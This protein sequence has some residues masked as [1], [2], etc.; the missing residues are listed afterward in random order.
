MVVQ[1]CAQGKNPLQEACMTDRIELLAAAL[2]SLPDGIAV[3]TGEGEV[4]FWNQAAEAITGFA[5]ADVLEHS[6]PEGLRPLL[7]GAQNGDPQLCADVE[8]G[9]GSL[10]RLRHKLGHEAPAIAR[11]FVLR[12]E[13]GE[14]IG[15]AAV[16]HPAESLDALPHGETGEDEDVL[17]SQ[18]DFEERLR[19]EFDDFLRGDEPLGVL[20]ISV[21]QA[22]E[23]RKSHGAG[24]CHAMLEK[25]RHALA[26]GLRPAEELGRWGDDEFLVIAHE[27][28]PEMLDAHA[29]VLAGLARTADFRWWGDRISL[30]VSIGA[31]QAAHGGETLAQLLECAREAMQSSIRSGGNCVTSAPGR[32]ACLPS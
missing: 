10:V 24:A 25:V 20:W 18:A 4:A 8:A 32:L 7:D 13:L 2:N 14:R 30:T 23:L 29:R 3:F 19:N 1:N 6:I 31:A 5:A 15:A 16:F 28:T 17:A 22:P 9:R 26:V 12:D 11:A 27:R 21:D